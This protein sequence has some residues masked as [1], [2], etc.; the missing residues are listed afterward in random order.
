M[1]QQSEVTGKYIPNF[2]GA[3]KFAELSVES[4]SAMKNYIAHQ[5]RDEINTT[6]ADYIERQLIAAIACARARDSE[7]YLHLGAALHAL[8]GMD[9]DISRHF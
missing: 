2:M 7:A 6:S 5:T 3:S 4:N 1:R 8:E 9:I